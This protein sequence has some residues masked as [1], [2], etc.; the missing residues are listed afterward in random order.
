MALDFHARIVRASDG[1]PV[2]RGTS[3]TLHA[4]LAS[5]AEGATVQEILADFPNLTDEDVRAVI[6]FA[7]VAAEEE[8]PVPAAG[9]LVEQALALPER[10]RLEVASELLAS[11][12]G[13]VDEDWDEAWLVELER[14]REAQRAAAKPASTWA[15]ARARILDRLGSR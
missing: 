8:L 4:V 12:D 2:I 11:V 7:A 3:V 6:A 1:R 5:L 9:K 14:R 13:P 10:D 15:E